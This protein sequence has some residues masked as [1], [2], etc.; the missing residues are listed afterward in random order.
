MWSLILQRVYICKEIRK[1]V[2]PVYNKSSVKN[3]CV[4]GYK[5]IYFHFTPL[6]AIELIQ[7][8][9]LLK[10]SSNLYGKLY[11]NNLKNSE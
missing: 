4:K 2:V 9:V 10:S 11:I 8:I 5:P 1:L 7:K 6:I 3:S